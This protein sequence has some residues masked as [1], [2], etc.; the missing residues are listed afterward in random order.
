MSIN[1]SP[2]TDFNTVNENF[3]T[4]ETGTGVS[5]VLAVTR[6]GPFN[7]PDEIFSSPERFKEVYGEE[8]VPDGTIS[9]IIRA[10]TSG[11]KVRVC[12]VAPV[13]DTGDGPVIAG[14]KG[15]LV[16]GMNSSGEKVLPLVNP[17]RGDDLDNLIILRMSNGVSDPYLIG[18]KLKTKNYGGD[19]QSLEEGKFASV[20]QQDGNF[21]NMK[22]YQT[23]LIPQLDDARTLVESRAMFNFRS[24]ATSP[25]N[26]IPSMFDLATFESFVENSLY[27]VEIYNYTALTLPLAVSDTPEPYSLNQFRSLIRNVINKDMSMK[28][29]LIAPSGLALTFDSALGIPM[30]GTEGVLELSMLKETDFIGDKEDGSGIYSFAD[31]SD[32]YEIVA[33]HLYQHLKND[34]GS[35][36]TFYNALVKYAMDSKSVI[37]WVELPKYK[38][39]TDDTPASYTDH[40]E[41]LTQLSLPFT[42]YAAAFTGGWSLPDDEGTDQPSDTLGTVMAIS[43]SLANPWDSLAGVK[44]G[45]VMDATSIVSRNYGSDSN[46][47]YLDQLAQAGINTSVMKKLTSGI[48]APVQWHNFTLLK[49]SSSLRFLSN[50]KTILFIKKNLKPIF[51]SYLEEPNS[52][53]TWRSIYYDAIEVLNPMVEKQALFKYEYIGDQ[54]A[55]NLSELKLNNEADVR[56]GKY[57]VKI[58]IWDIVK[59]QLIEVDIIIERASKSVSVSIQNA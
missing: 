57:R 17:G 47:P 5:F 28:F 10:L 46:Y 43:A 22:T 31:Y 6:K 53:P 4:P 44:N 13:N 58:K 39:G 3:Y 59:L 7:K 18:F 56:A 50:I 55:K 24:A 2:R 38:H 1:K 23:N 19:I 11:G 25:E 54:F 32:S 26:P 40:I 51:D 9:N 37:A 20:L 41:F 27:E 12:R 48:T 29:S 36:R 8:I 21:M 42:P 15:K 16:L 52:F 45:T 30:F 33:S 35:C 34:L 49:D 14:N